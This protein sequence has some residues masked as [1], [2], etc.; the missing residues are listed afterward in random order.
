MTTFENLRNSLLTPIY[1][2]RLGLI[3]G[4]FLA[5][6]KDIVKATQSLTS[7]STG[8]QV[9][10]YGITMLDVTTAAASTASSIGTTELG[11]SWTMAAPQPGVE[12]L[13][14]KVSATAG[15][16]MPVVVEFGTGVTAFD[17]SLGSTFTGTMMNAVGQFVRLM[18][19]STSQWVV[20]GKSTAT[21]LASSN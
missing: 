16:T 14:M 19:I 12:K 13:L 17:S 1:G 4:E 7:G 20:M 3:N 11:C 21:T 10:N 6:P 2:R 9:T 18:G 15:S 5:G 8:T